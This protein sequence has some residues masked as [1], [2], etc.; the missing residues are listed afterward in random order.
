MPVLPAPYALA[1]HGR[2]AAGRDAPAPGV[3]ASRGPAAPE[4]VPVAAPA[5]AL[6]RALDALRAQAP[7]LEFVVD[8]RRS[9]VRVV[10]RE[11]GEVL[12]E[13]PPR[14]AIAAS[15]AIEHMQ[16]LLIRLKA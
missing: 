6:E 2:Q 4:P 9:V 8:G 14:E 13:I 5:P 10:D 7:A 3:A 16:G 11:T 1:A 12:R 15:R